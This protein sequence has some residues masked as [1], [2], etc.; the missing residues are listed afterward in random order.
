MNDKDIYQITFI[1]NTMGEVL[2]LVKVI[3]G[4]MGQMNYPQGSKEWVC[5][6][7]ST[8]L[9]LDNAIN[10]ETFKLNSEMNI[11]YISN[12]GTNAYEI[13]IDNAIVQ[14]FIQ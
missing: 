1:I 12:L 3:R 11:K 8:I 4:W 14:L 10:V 6:Y 2:P 13:R 5:P 7:F 9:D